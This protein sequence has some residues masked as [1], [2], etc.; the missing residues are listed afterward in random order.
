MSNSGKYKKFETELKKL[1]NIGSLRSLKNI[2][3]RYGKFVAFNNKRL[4]NLSSND[5]LDIAGKKE[6]LDEF[7]RFFAKEKDIG[8]G[9]TSS[10]LLTGNHSEYDK[11]EASIAKWNNK[12]AALF[13]NSGY[14]ANLG[15]LP[16][17]ASKGD[18]I[19]SDK[20]NH[21]SII[22][23]IRLSTTHFERYKHTDYNHLEQILKKK[24][25]QY[26]N[27]FI[28]TET[29]FSMD[30]DIVDL[31]RLVWLK[32]KFDCF[33]Y[34]DEAHAAGLYGKR[35]AGITDL[36]NLA[37]EIDI[38]VGTCGKAMASVGA[39]AAINH[40]LKEFLVNKMRT[41]IF[42]TAL[43]PVNILWNRFVLQKIQEMNQARKHLS[44]LSEQFRNNLKTLGIKTLGQTNIIPVIIGDN[45]ITVRL[46]EH[47]QK[48]GFL[49]FPIRPPTVPANSARL[50]IS[51][52]A[53]IEWK[54]IEQ[55]PG[56]I[57]DF[58]HDKQ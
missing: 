36:N 11:L 41:L 7:Y 55:L 42:T 9:G 20:L 29:V 26:Q 49:V 58:L 52:T 23:G 54:D 17:L 44:L 31:E 37:S 19:L 1:K 16:A 5:Y 48:N 18:L 10:R 46:A 39:Y 50:R 53:D 43:P 38:I 15:I 57:H 12:E 4:L 51:L 40:I 3:K 24:R 2:G 45:L 25:A 14:H 47:L 30:G 33:L 35:G 28:I 21:A 22:D 13:F 6:F 56:L 32:N 34:V 27:V 8:L